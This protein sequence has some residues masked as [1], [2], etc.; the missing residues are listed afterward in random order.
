VSLLFP[1]NDEAGRRAR[2]ERHSPRLPPTKIVAIG[3]ARR[4]ISRARR[5]GRRAE[6]GGRP[7][8]LLLLLLLCPFCSVCPPLLLHTAALLAS[9]ALSPKSVPCG[10]P[11][12]PRRPSS[13]GPVDCCCVW[14]G[15]RESKVRRRPRRRRARRGGRRTRRDPGARAP[16]GDKGRTM[17]PSCNE[18]GVGGEGEGQCERGR[19]SLLQRKRTRGAGGRWRR[20]SP[21]PTGQSPLPADGHLFDAAVSPNASITLSLI[22]ERPRTRPHRIH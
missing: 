13:W 16:P 7:P 22:S 14:R 19:G 21:P 12:G 2:S 5:G 8:K 6:T 10:P 18:R 20:W 9:S 3:R 11:R 15:G 4:P 17:M 1:P